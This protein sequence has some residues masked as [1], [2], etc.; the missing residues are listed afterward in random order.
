[1][2][3]IAGRTPLSDLAE[4]SSAAKKIVAAHISAMARMRW[5]K[6]D[7]GI[8]RM[9]SALESR[10]SAAMNRFHHQEDFLNPAV[11]GSKAP[12]PNFGEP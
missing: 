10:A 3:S 5:R 9:G 1:M 4:V 7:E 8:A 2:I 6:A 12:A 11:G